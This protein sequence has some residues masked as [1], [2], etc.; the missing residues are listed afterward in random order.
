MLPNL[1]LNHSFSKHDIDGLHAA[2]E[3][4]IAE[5]EKQREPGYWA[6]LK[7][8]IGVTHEKSVRQKGRE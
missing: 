8:F 1:N 6:T 7:R 4:E 2:I 5:E 3:A